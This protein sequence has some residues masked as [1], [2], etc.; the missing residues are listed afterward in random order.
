MPKQPTDYE[1]RRQQQYA[2]WMQIVALALFGKPDRQNGDDWR[3]GNNGGLSIDIGKGVFYDFTDDTSGGVI[4]LIM[5]E[6]SEE[7]E[8]AH[9]TLEEIRKG[10]CNGQPIP[11]VTMPPHATRRNGYAPGPAQPRIWFDEAYDYCDENDRLLF[12]VLRYH[13]IDEQGNPLRK[14]GKIQ[15]VF[16]QRRPSTDG[17]TN[18]TPNVQGVRVVPYNLS[19]VLDTIKNKAHVFVVEGERKVNFLDD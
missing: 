10:T 18:W 13:Y 8:D 12:Q 6:C 9:K 14:N 11:R 5:R 2:E 16:K 7:A 19:Q 17:K 15:K 3:Y 4:D 1:R